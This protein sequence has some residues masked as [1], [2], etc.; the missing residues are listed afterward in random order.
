MA[1]LVPLVAARSQRGRNDWSI[2]LITASLAGA[3]GSSFL[4]GYNLSVVNAPTVFIKKFYNET[5]ER[6][7]NQS[8]TEQSLTLLW[9]LSVSIFAVGGLLGALI[10]TPA[11]KYFE[12]ERCC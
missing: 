2:S 11:V 8:I 9:T 6:R 10:V 4:Y 1:N 3:F 12:S 7:Y 5:W